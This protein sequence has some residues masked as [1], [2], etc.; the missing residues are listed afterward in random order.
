MKFSFEKAHV[1]HQFGLTLIALERY[2]HAVSVMTE[3]SQLLPY[4]SSVCLMIAKV[5]YEH[6]SQ[7]SEGIQWS[8]KVSFF[9]EKRN[10]PLIIG[11][12]SSLLSLITSVRD[13]EVYNFSQVLNFIFSLNLSLTKRN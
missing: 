11:C 9:F 8:Q 13:S 1:W 5:C 12:L 6:L 4:D 10:L 3:V 2:D 7:Y